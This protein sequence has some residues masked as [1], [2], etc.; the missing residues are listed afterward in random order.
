MQLTHLTQAQFQKFYKLLGLATLASVP[1]VFVG[2]FWLTCLLFTATF[3]CFMLWLYHHVTDEPPPSFGHTQTAFT[4]MQPG[5]TPAD[6]AA[7]A[8]VGTAATTEAAPTIAPSQVVGPGGVTTAVAPTVA[9]VAPG[10]PVI[11]IGASQPPQA[12]NPPI[13][14]IRPTQNPPQQ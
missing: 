10:T 7:A 12:D 4:P 9:P 3:V 1:L 6:P 14:V 8:L 5:Q 11:G 13:A 2:M